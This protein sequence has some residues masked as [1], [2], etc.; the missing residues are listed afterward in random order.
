MY[1]CIFRRP[2]MSLHLPTADDV[3][4]VRL[5]SQ[6]TAEKATMLTDNLNLRTAVMALLASFHRLVFFIS[7][8]A[9]TLWSIY[10][11]V[12][13][14]FI[15]SYAPLS[16]T[17]MPVPGSSVIRGAA[18]PWAGREHS[19]SRHLHIGRKSSALMHLPHIHELFSPASC[20]DAGR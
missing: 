11:R 17:F 4:A 19:F 20:N 14:S 12:L 8:S 18:P 6:C 13:A 5:A 3:V 1:R 15:E 10:S 2:T 7:K 9:S 16:H